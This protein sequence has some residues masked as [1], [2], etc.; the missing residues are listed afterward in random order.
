[1]VRLKDAILITLSL[2]L[3]SGMA[4][5]CAVPSAGSPSQPPEQQLPLPEQ[6]PPPVSTYPADISGQVII[7]QKVIAKY[8]SESLAG[9]TMEMNPLEGQI[10]WIVDISVKNKSYESEVMANHTHWKIVADDNIYDA[11]RPFMSIQPA[12]PMTVPMGETGETI[13]RFPVKDTLQ[14]SEA[15]ICYQGQE[16]YSYGNLVGGERVAVY[17]WDLKTV[18]EEPE[19]AGRG[20]LEVADMW[21]VDFTAWVSIMVQ[22][23]STPQT[24]PG[25]YHVRLLSGKEDFGEKTIN[26]SENKQLATLGWDISITDR[27]WAEL[28]RGESCKDV[29]QVEISYE[30]Y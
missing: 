20:Y 30:P 22:L 8:Q 24:K 28:Q 18:I 21:G 19:V 26:W 1:M 17:D 11:Q 27:A 15:K 23:E 12:Y 6:Q 2:V 25:H 9:E 3:A 5:S 7:A 16:P 14:I 4:I 13:I 29:F 10:Y